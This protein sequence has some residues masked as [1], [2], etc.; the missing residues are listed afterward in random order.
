M[1]KLFSSTFRF[2]LLILL[3]QFAAHTLSANLAT[4]VT[5]N[6]SASQIIESIPGRPVFGQNLFAGGFGNVQFAGFNPEYQISIGDVISLQLWGGFEV[7]TQLTVDAQGNVFI[8]NIGPVKL[9]GVANKDLNDTLAKKVASVYQKNV[10]LY[11]SLDASQ[12]VKLFVTGFVKKPGLYGGL[13]SDSILSYLEKASGINNRSGS[14]LDIQLKRNGTTIEHYNLYQFILTGDIVYRQLHDGDVLVVGPK[15]STVMFDGLVENTAQLEFA[16]SE[17]NLQ[18]AL[19]IVG[20]RPEVTHLRITRGNRIKQEVEYIALNDSKTTVVYNGDTVDAVADKPKGTIVVF[21]EGEHEGSAEYVLPYG[22]TLEQLIK[23]IKPSPHSL[24]DDMQLFRESVAKRQK[25]MLLLSLQ[26][27]ENV[28][29]SARSGSVGEANLRAS[30]AKMIDQFIERAKQVEPLGH[31]ILGN[32]EK[33]DQII[34]Q[35]RDRILIP[36]ESLLVQVHGEVMFPSAMVWQKDLRAANYIEAA[37][38]LTQK[39]KQS[40]VLIIQK[41]GSIRNLTGNRSAF[42]NKKAYVNPGDEILVLPQVDTKGMQFALDIS[43]IIYQIAL[44]AR[45]AVLL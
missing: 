6:E 27:L 24:M 30:D 14:Y 19:D 2:C 44:V 32:N 41:D 29:Y 37:G 11:A 34:L 3:A 9:L 26:R 45:V 28:T 12:P 31:V 22:A 39:N 33:R 13:S 17:L 21:V 8:P 35:N 43:Q 18:Q 5:A 40:R 10:K 23:Q 15:Q 36:A 16:G 42:D 38:G 25:E 1:I 20:L 7:T 4:T